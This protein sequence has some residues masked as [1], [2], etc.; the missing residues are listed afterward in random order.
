MYFADNNMNCNK[1]LLIAKKDA[2]CMTI[3]GRKQIP[4]VTCVNRLKGIASH[5]HWIRSWELKSTI[6]LYMVFIFLKIYIQ[7]LFLSE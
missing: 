4:C 3:P 7:V 5:Q 6:A 1:V 2:Q